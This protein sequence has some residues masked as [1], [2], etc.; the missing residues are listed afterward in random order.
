MYDFG[1]LDRRSLLLP[2]HHPESSGQLQL[3]AQFRQ[4]GQRGLI[5]R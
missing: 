4:P 2:R 3:P 1:V 5:F